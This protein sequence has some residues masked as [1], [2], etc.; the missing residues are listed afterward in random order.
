MGFEIASRRSI[1]SLIDDGTICRHKDGNYGSSYPRTSEFG[2]VGV[3]LLTAKFVDDGGRIDIASAARLNRKKAETLTYGFIEAD[4]VLLSHNATVGR[5]ALVP[6]LDEPV[7]VGTSLTYYRVDS[8]RLLP[9]YLAA[10]LRGDDFQRQLQAVMSHSTRNQV[11]ITAQRKLE[12]VVPPLSEQRAIA[13]VLGSLDD[14]IALNRRMNRTLE[15]LARCLFQS[16]FVDFDPI[17]VEVD[18]MIADRILEIGDGYRAKNSELAEEGLPFVRARNLNIGFDLKGA[19]RLAFESV[20]RAV[21]KISRPGDVAFTSKGTVGRLARVDESIDRFVY[22]PQVCY[23]RSRSAKDLHPVVLY[24]WMSSSLFLDQVMGRA[25][26]TDM[27]AYISLKDQRGLKIP[28]FPLGQFELGEKL[29]P[30][31]DAKAMN[32]QQSRTLA[33]LRDALLPKLLGGELAT[34]KLES[35][36]P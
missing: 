10:F 20:E 31:L 28:R 35:L 19:D 13:A 7:L 17:H 25:Y 4:D 33:A 32:E 1:Q 5:V 11:P 23:W 6:E 27:A 3:P 18:E 24:C 14:K 12:I 2:A 9:K 15:S 29:K 22:A 26:Q 16:W 21:N 30:L 34:D 36:T 8:T